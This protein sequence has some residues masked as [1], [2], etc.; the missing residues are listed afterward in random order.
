MGISLIRDAY[1]YAFT[2]FTPSV[3]LLQSSYDSAED[4]DSHG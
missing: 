3:F 4:H 2:R 1:G